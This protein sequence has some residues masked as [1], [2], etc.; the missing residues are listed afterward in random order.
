V[1]RN[2]LIQFADGAATCVSSLLLYM[3]TFVAPEERQKLVV[4]TKC[5]QVTYTVSSYFFRVTTCGLFLIRINLVG[6]TPWT[7]ESASRKAATYTQDSTNV[8]ETG[9][10][11]HASTGI[12]THDP[13]L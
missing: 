4:D 10:N 11:I 6:R 9:T 12:R 3:Q 5:L 7:G 8:D 13:T 2:Y 1:K